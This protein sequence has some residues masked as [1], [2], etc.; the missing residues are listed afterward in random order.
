[1]IYASFLFGMNWYIFCDFYITYQQNKLD[2]D[3]TDPA[4]IE[5]FLTYF[6][7]KEQPSIKDQMWTLTYFAFT[8][9]STVGFGD[10]HPRNNSERTIGAMLMLMGA[11]INSFVIESLQHMIEQYAEITADFEENEHLALFLNTIKKYN[12]GFDLPTEQL[13]EIRQYFEYRW[14]HHR[15]QAI[16]SEEDL[17]QYDNLHEDY[18]KK[19]FVN[20]LFKDLI[21][22][23]HKL[24]LNVTAADGLGLEI[25]SPTSVLKSTTSLKSINHGM[26]I[27][28]KADE[29]QDF[30]FEMVK[31]L[32]PRRLESN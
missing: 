28:K 18:Q 11:M 24:F 25:M 29:F 5:N 22:L 14:S 4:Y 7:I 6:S 13:E 16:S 30:L 3:E 20:Y 19:L 10:Y 31:T 2:P 32:E 15:N 8:T 26:V 23:H 27:D 9:I 1:M 12:G 17:N 21:Q